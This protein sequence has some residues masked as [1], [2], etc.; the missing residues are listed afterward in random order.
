ML[1]KIQLPQWIPTALFVLLVPVIGFLVVWNVEQTRQ[2][3]DAGAQTEAEAQMIGYMRQ[4]F[5]VRHQR[6]GFHWSIGR[7]DGQNRLVCYCDA[8]GYGWWYQVQIGSDGQ[9][10]ASQVADTSAASRVTQE[11]SLFPT[12]RP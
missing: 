8:K 3:E 11:P 9:F 4:Q 7:R 5:E 6:W 1:T 2:Q 10:S 12:P